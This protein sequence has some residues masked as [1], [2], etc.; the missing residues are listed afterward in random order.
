MIKVAVLTSGMHLIG[1]VTALN[2]DGTLTMSKPRLVVP[3]GRGAASI[4]D[5]S[6]LT[7]AEEDV[8]LDRFQILRL[9]DED[10]VP[11]QVVQSYKAKLS[12]LSLHH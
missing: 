3:V 1:E 7:S 8:L 6:F 10:D 5:V 4:T 12:G 11:H 2:D 9:L